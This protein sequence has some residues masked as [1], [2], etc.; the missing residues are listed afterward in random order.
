MADLLAKKAPVI[1][2]IQLERGGSFLF[3]IS[4][5]IFL[6]V[7]AGTGGLVLLNRAQA[8]ALQ[9]LTEEVEDKENGLRS[10]LVNQIFLIDQRLRNLRTLL[11]EHTASANVFALLEKNTLP[12]VRFLNFSFDASARKLDMSGEAASYSAIAK[13]IGVFERDPNIE[14]VEFGGL[15]LSASNVAGFKVALIFK[16]SFLGFRP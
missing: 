11:S 12:Q 10:E 1:S 2:S 4:L 5:A 6:F 3:Y 15:S 8:D 13:Q 9:V 16:R 14:K 7:A